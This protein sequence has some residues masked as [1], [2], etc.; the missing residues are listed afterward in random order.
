MGSNGR[1]RDGQATHLPLGRVRSTRPGDV[2]RAMTGR[3]GPNGAKLLELLG[4]IAEGRYIPRRKSDGSLVAGEEQEVN[5]DRFPSL[6]LQTR[7]AVLLLERMIGKVPDM[8]VTADA[9]ERPRFDLSKVKSR[10]HLKVLR[11]ILIEQAPTRAELAARI[12]DGEVVG[13]EPDGT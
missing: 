12:S 13:G 7:V 1:G 3:W 11:E 2:A 5:P 10:E 8:V 6:E 9:T 4:D